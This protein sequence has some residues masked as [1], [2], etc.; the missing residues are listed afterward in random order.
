M[1]AP[2]TWTLKPSLLSII[3][4]PLIWLFVAGLFVAAIIALLQLAGADIVHTHRVL[5]W[6]AGV[7][8]ARLIFEVLTWI[9]TSFTLS[10]TSIIT[11]RGIL[12]RS[13]VEIPL[14][15][16]QHIELFRGIRERLIGAGTIGLGTGAGIEAVLDWVGDARLVL[17]S[18]RTAMKL[19]KSARPPVLGLVGSIG[20]G[21]STFAAAFKARGCLVLDSD[22]A[23]KEALKRPEV[24][25][26]IVGWWGTD[27]LDARGQIDRSRLGAIVFSDPSK[28]KQLEGLTHPLLKIDRVAEIAKATGVPAII[29]DAPLLFEAGVDAECDAVICVDAP[30]EL[31]LQRVSTRGWDGA[32]LDRREAAQLSIQ[33]KRRRSRWVIENSGSI[34]SLNAQADSIL[35]QIAAGPLKP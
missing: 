33:E 14:S 6:A 22:T 28:R 23:A 9:C 35:T 16:I 17:E 25:A 19:N 10:S 31:R 30:R 15:R 21:K 34:E 5:I 2:G 13:T 4:R 7:V 32:E 20:A 26:T 12:R 3:A 11:R 1:Q 29:I 27:V 24:I 18:I 8:I